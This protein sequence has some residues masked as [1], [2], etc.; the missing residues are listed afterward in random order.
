MRY[1][2][3]S[4]RKI[5]Q[6]TKKIS[7]RIGK[8]WSNDSADFSDYKKSNKKRFRYKFI[9]TDNFSKYTWANPLNKK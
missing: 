6:L 8:I 4:L 1:T 9:K 3:P 2:L 7:N 5:I